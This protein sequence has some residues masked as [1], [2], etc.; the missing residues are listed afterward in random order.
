MVGILQMMVYLFYFLPY[1]VAAVYGLVWP[2]NTWMLDLSLIHA[3]AAAQ[4]HNCVNVRLS[5]NVQ[6]HCHVVT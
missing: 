3:G 4:V 5:T 6:V 2:E 1:Y